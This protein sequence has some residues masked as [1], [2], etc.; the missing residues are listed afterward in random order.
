MRPEAQTAALAALELTDLWGVAHR[1]AARLAA[2]GLDTPL[3]LRDADPSHVRD[4]LGVVMERMVLELQGVPCHSLIQTAPANKTIVASRSFGRA[5]LTR[6]ELTAAVSSHVERAAEK[7]RRQGL[8]AGAIRV[9]VTTNPFK[10]R[11]PQYAAS[12]GIHLPVATA[13]TALLLRAARQALAKLWRPN[14]R[15]KKAGVELFD[16]DQAQNA[17]GD[18]WTGPDS[19]RRKTLMACIDGIN[20]DHGRGTIRFAASGFAE[21]WKLRADSR[22]PHYTTDWCQ[23]LEVG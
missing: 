15:Y 14:F 8:A 16:I 3:K 1:L 13:D 23:L 17:Q 11:E 22:S 10:P 6:D 18:L 5:V 12:K 7:L 2:L 19:D 20:A 4:R 9:F 21:G